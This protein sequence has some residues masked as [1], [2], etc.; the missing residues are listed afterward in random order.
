MP[1]NAL[2]LS[3]QGQRNPAMFGIIIEDNYR[4]QRWSS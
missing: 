2:N 3:W 1:F 4:I